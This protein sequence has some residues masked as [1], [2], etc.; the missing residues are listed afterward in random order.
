ME[1]IEKIADEFNDIFKIIDVVYNPINFSF[2]PIDTVIDNFNNALTIAKNIDFSII[3]SELHNELND[4]DDVQDV[5]NQALFLFAIIINWK[6]NLVDISRI[7]ES[8]KDDLVHYFEKLDHLGITYT[9]QEK[10]TVTDIFVMLGLRLLKARLDLKKII[11]ELES[12]HEIQKSISY[13]NINKIA[14][15]NLKINP[16]KLQD[17]TGLLFELYK[18]DY[19]LPLD[20]RISNGEVDLILAFE[21]FLDTDI[22]GNEWFGPSFYSHDDK[23]PSTLALQHAK[24]TPSISP[25]QIRIELNA[26]F[27]E[28]SQD[29]YLESLRNEFKAEKGKTI[30]ILLYV[31]Q[32]TNPPILSI[33]HGKM[34]KFYNLLKAFFNTNI[35]TYQSITNFAVNKNLHK[36]EIKAIQLRVE[37][38]KLPLRTQ[39]NEP[40]PVGRIF[41]QN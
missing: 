1:N 2:D 4:N 37:N 12:I 36:E 24:T 27:A 30:A 33:P 31:L 40:S 5:I 3:E 32:N 17:F 25:A 18:N 20:A 29:N 22:S 8:Q 6:E 23:I 10:E 35:G 26:Y 15:Y 38:L 21:T 13:L 11:E 9:I 16:D 34:K 19:F 7:K 41:L 39:T 28:S 14:E